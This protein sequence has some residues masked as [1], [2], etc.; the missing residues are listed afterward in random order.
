[1]RSPSPEHCAS[2]ATG[3]SRGRRRLQ[4]AASWE[5]TMTTQRR[6]STAPLGCATGGNAQQ[7]LS[8]N[9]TARPISRPCASTNR[10][11]TS[12]RRT[13]AGSVRREAPPLP[14]RHELPEVPGGGIRHTP[15]ERRFFLGGGRGRTERRS[16][17]GRSQIR[18]SL[19]A[20][21]AP[22]AELKSGPDLLWWILQR[23]GKCRPSANSRPDAGVVSR[24]DR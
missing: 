15:P 16:S 22:G 24:R 2:C 11:R 21:A 9:R 7:G 14:H 17:P 3:V 1:V 20:R 13:R 18:Q 12:P 6:K 10:G 8:G 4:L 5:D 23:S 19:F